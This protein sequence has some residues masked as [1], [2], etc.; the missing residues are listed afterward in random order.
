MSGRP[1]FPA[2]M[3]IA[4]RVFKATLPYNKIFI[5]P[6]LGFQDL[7]FTTTIPPLVAGPLASGYS[8]N[9][10]LDGFL[11]GM[12]ATNR[13]ATL[14]HELTHV[15]QGAHRFISSRYMWESI[16]HQAIDWVR[17]TDCYRYV[18]GNTWSSYNV[19]QQASIVED[20]FKGGESTTDPLFRYIQDDIRS[21]ISAASFGSSDDV[22]RPLSP[23]G[24]GVEA[25]ARRRRACLRV[26][27]YGFLL[28]RPCGTDSLTVRV[29]GTDSRSGSR[30]AAHHRRDFGDGGAAR[31]ASSWIRAAATRAPGGDRCRQGRF[32]L[33]GKNDLSR[34]ADLCKFYG[35]VR[36]R[37]RRQGGPGRRRGFAR[38]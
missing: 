33:R 1:L 11:H 22:L 28:V 18:P 2:E 3:E 32:W 10:G 5:S 21:L 9:I 16:A 15:W 7:P 13:A 38:R 24:K 30:K 14:V 35:L 17:G 4:F 27:R 8:I 6:F 31:R 20:W 23:C 34:K 37:R 12:D 29:A 25:G 19:E 36:Y 26:G